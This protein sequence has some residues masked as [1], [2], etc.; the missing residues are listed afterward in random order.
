MVLVGALAGCGGGSGGT[1][2]PASTKL[3]DLSD[4]QKASLC[5]YINGKQG[6]YGK[7]IQ[8]PDGPS[9]NDANQ[10]DCVAFVGPLGTFCPT[11]TAGDLEQCANGPMGNTCT[12]QTAPECKAVADC[13]NSLAAP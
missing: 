10:A 9:D 2:V 3:G 8:C 4:T 12:F 7:T 13:I 11:L 6:G 5:D 1:G